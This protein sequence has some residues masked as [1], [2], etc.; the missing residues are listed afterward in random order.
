MRMMDPYSTLNSELF[1]RIL[2]FPQGAG[3]LN[4]KSLGTAG[5]ESVQTVPPS[6]KC[7]AISKK[8]EYIDFAYRYIYIERETQRHRYRYKCTTSA[9]LVTHQL[10]GL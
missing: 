1:V 4:E 6:L 10:P 3:L 7:R 2:S 8:V 5:L 9:I